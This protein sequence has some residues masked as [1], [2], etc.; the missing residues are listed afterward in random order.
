MLSFVYLQSV[1]M[2]LSLYENNFPMRFGLILY[3]SK[4]IKKATSHGLHLSA[5]ENDGETEEDISSLVFSFFSF[6]FFFSFLFP[7]TLIASLT[8]GVL[9]ACQA[10][11]ILTFGLVIHGISI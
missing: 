3:S 4:F 10:D 6:H 7:L 1:D 11:F 5:E 2:I 8:N 9:S